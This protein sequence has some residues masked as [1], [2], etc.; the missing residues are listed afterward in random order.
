MKINKQQLKVVFEAF[1]INEDILKWEGLVH[2]EKTINE[3]FILKQYVRV[4]TENASYILKLLSLPM[5][6]NQTL[7]IQSR[8]SELYRENGIPTPKRFLAKNGF[9]LMPYCMEEKEILI[10]LEEDAGDQILDFS[11]DIIVF[12]GRLLGKMHAISMGNK[13]RFRPGSLY[14]EFREGKTTY[15]PLWKRT[16]TDFL[17]SDIF[18]RIL[19]LYEEHMIEMKKT[20]D[21]L[22]RYTVQSD[23]Y[24]MNLTKKDGKIRIIDYDRVGDEVLLADMLVTWFRFRF[25]PMIRNAFEDPDAIELWEKF[26]KAYE[27]ERPLTENEK[28]SFVHEYAVI[29]AVFCTKM[30]ADAAAC[31]DKKYAADN[32]KMI[33]DVLECYGL[34]EVFKGN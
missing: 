28:E 10:S 15:L 12:M 19:K 7:E 9:Y 24:R 26:L 8:F 30:L 29:G 34:Q 1:K 3:Q 6:S 20:W 27:K 22:P 32:L 5:C 31:G 23:M 17:P 33:L 13:C 16:G 2:I 14:C 4:H 21:I 18:E 11:S 25:D